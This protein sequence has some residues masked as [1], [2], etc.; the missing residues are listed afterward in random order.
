MNCGFEDTLVF[1]EVLDET[2]D[3]LSKA[4]P[5]FAERRRP[6][7]EAINILSFNNYAEMRSHTASRLFLFRKQVEVRRAALWSRRRRRCM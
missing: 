6:D 4:V 1:N 5:L 2:G 7:A 3:D